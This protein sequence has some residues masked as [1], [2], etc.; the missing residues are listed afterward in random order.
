MLYFVSY[1]YEFNQKLV[2]MEPTNIIGATDFT[3]QHEIRP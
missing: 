1:L 2:K 3:E